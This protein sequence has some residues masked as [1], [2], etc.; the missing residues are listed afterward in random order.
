MDAIKMQQTRRVGRYCT[1]VLGI[2]SLIFGIVGLIPTLVDST[3]FDYLFGVFLWSTNF[4]QNLVHCA[5]GIF[6]IFSYTSA[7]RARIFN[8]LF[9]IS[10]ILIALLGAIPA[11]HIVFELMPSFSSNVLLNGLIAFAALCYSIVFPT[12]VNDVG[13][14]RNI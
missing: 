9:T 14:S 2:T 7:S 10:Y 13:G 6:G 3:E 4:F 12:K 8:Y 1:L 11:T 5:V